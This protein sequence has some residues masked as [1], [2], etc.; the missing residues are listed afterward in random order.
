MPPHR[1]RQPPFQ[2]KIF[3]TDGDLH[4]HLGQLI[5]YARSA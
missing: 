2:A 1:H 4:E 3:A 5:T